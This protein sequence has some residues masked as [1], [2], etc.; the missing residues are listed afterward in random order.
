[1]AFVVHLFFLSLEA[2]DASEENHFPRAVRYMDHY[3][4]LN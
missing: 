2:G 1:M 4:V 3:K